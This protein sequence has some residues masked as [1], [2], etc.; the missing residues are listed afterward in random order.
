MSNRAAE[1]RAGDTA[2]IRTRLEAYYSRYYDGMLRI[3]GWRDLVA[4]RLDDVA[5]ER[6]RLERLEMAL[7]RS[8]A[9]AR[10]LNVGCGTGGVNEF[11][12]SGGA[13]GLGVDAWFG[14]ASVGGLGAPGRCLGGP[15]V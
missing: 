5:Y 6:R 13:P 12:R 15:W 9:G 14:G 10:L 3:P 1:P 8:V 7:G 11:V 2:A 4:V